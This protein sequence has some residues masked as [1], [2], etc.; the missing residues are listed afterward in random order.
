[1]EENGIHMRKWLEQ[2][3]IKITILA[4]RLF[5]IIKNIIEYDD[6]DDDVEI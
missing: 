2:R 4:S 6:V 5:L 1:M 3:V